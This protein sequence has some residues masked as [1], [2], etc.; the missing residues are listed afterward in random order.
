MA[1]ATTRNT[2][3]Q[4][5]S[6][7]W[8]DAF[9]K[10]AMWVTF[11]LAAQTSVNIGV[12]HF[13]LVFRAS[14]VDIID[15]TFIGI[16]L[17]IYIYLWGNT[18]FTVFMRPGQ[19][20]PIPGK[21]IR[22]DWLETYKM[23]GIFVITTLT[24]TFVT[25]SLNLIRHSSLLIPVWWYALTCVV[26]S[27][28]IVLLVIR[29]RNRHIEEYNKIEDIPYQQYHGLEATALRKLSKLS[30]EEQ[31]ELLNIV[32]K[33]D[34]ARQATVQSLMRVVWWSLLFSLLAELLVGL[35]IQL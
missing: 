13:L 19:K 30:R 11:S 1:K 4:G 17:L 28:R 32:Y 23:S 27:F 15:R 31:R 7:N 29:W 5:V 10:N 9:M 18:F 34:L 12:I 22:H 26:V 35:V 14:D 16:Q 2:K 20:W 33:T 21:E 8:L 3:P 25:N 24:S 6:N